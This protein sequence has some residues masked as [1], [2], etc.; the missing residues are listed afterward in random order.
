MAHF[1]ISMTSFLFFAC[2]F[3]E[4]FKVVL[5]FFVFMVADAE[6]TATWRGNHPLQSLHN[7][8]AELTRSNARTASGAPLE[9]A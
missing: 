9:Q 2:T 5:G 1:N 6:L 8:D 4:N 7:V 3:S